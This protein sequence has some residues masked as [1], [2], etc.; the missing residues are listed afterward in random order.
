MKKNAIICLGI[1]C[2][3]R[4]YESN[5]IYLSKLTLLNDSKTLIVTF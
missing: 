2:N 1:L 5:N 3:Y 4:K